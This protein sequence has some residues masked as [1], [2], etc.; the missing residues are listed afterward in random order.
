MPIPASQMVDWQKQTAH[1]SH[2][3]IGYLAGVGWIGR[4]NLLVSKEYGSQFRLSTILTNMP[5]KMDEP[6]KENCGSCR[7]CVVLCPAQAIKEEVKEF[8]HLKCYAQIKEF[9]K[10]KLVDQNICGICINN[11][12]GRFST[13]VKGVP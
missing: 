12:K 2:K 9:Q 4:N 7:M 8:D 3:K 1:L 11:C 13:T 6:L 10:Q 5:L